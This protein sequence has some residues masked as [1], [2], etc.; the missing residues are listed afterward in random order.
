[1]HLDARTLTD[2]TSAEA[3][4]C[5]VGAGAAGI[6]LAM[7]L[8]GSNRQVLLLESGGFEFEEKV[9]SLY[10]GSNTGREY[11]APD[12]AR[13]R[14][15]GGTTN[16]WA[17]WCAPLEPGDFEVRDWIPLSG[18]PVRYET[19][20]PWY[21]R[22]QEICQLGPFEYTPEYWERQ[23]G[24]QRLPLSR[25]EIATKI[26]QFSPP[27]RFG[28]VYREAIVNARNV[29]LW[30]HAN[31]TDIQSDGVASH[32]TGMEVRTLDKKRVSVRAKRYVLACGGLENA[33]ILMLSNRVNPEGLGN[34]NGVVGRYFMEHPHVNTSTLLLS[35][36]ANVQF[37]TPPGG[38]FLPLVELAPAA[39]RHFR[40]A[41]YSAVLFP[42]S[43]TESSGPGLLWQFNARL[44]QVPNPDSRITLSRERRDSLGLPQLD[45][46]W[47][48]TKFD[49]KSLLSGELT[50]AREFGR[51]SLGRV[52]VPD[53]MMRDD[54]Q[55]PGSD[56]MYAGPHA[57]GATRMS[58]NPRRGVVDADCKVHG[59]DNLFV[60]GSSV[61]ATAGTSN[62]TL[63]VVA[64]AARLA[65]HLER[66]PA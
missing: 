64:L 21:R 6:T 14:F 56:D 57:M 7:Q 27:T 32:V 65:D 19:L 1:L 22:A 42:K 61:F 30:T 33:R 25:D 60:V 63:T 13:L 11:Y 4:V 48:L 49:K 35:R 43:P 9:Q 53:W 23:S 41:G 38:A 5:I 37:Y 15:F 3:D 24:L 12:V 47:E 59:I 51:K 36:R 52:R 20:E 44:E 18:W 26:I 40:T 39:Q 17:G 34:Q 28:Q 2:N 58:D 31:A 45:V 46:H 62:P 54:D 10:Q 16:H 8:T 29:T 50:L 66:R 55:W